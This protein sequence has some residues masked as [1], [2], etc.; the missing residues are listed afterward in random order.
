MKKII[1]LFLLFLTACSN[2]EVKKIKNSDNNTHLQEQ[3]K[4]ESFYKEWHGVPYKYGGTDKN[5]VDCSGFVKNLFSQ[6]YNIE[7]PRNTTLQMKN[8]KKIDYFERTK[9]DLVFFKTGKNTYHVG[10]YYENDNFIHSS[11]SKGVMMS[12]LNESYWINNFLELR[13]V[14]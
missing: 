8:G 5:G 7:L 11:T 4:L 9:G 12:N 3:K 6:V 14:M 10:V 2:N 1:I 13:R